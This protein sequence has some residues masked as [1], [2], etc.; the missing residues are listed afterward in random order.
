[1][2]KIN[3]GVVDWKKVDKKPKNVHVKTIN[4]NYAVELGKSKAFGFSLVGIGG[5]DIAQ[6]RTKLVLAIVWQMMRYHI[7]RF[8]TAMSGSSK[9]LTEADV[10][11][12]ANEKVAAQ[13]GLLP[14][15]KLSDATLASGVYILTLIK[16]VAPRA[17]D[18]QQVT[19]GM[20]AEEKKLNARLAVS[21]ARRAGCMI[22]ALWEDIV[23][24]K[25]KM[26]LVLFATLMQLDI[27][28]KSEAVVGEKRKELRRLS[29]LAE[30]PESPGKSPH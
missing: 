5:V 21:C 24:C 20:T 15:Q 12:W 2:D 28:N 14:V 27:K 29:V 3:P 9:A 26:L 13:S 18:L 7:I 6:K 4:C 23:E 30:G 11:K 16:A 17:V 1:M 25:P 10:L 22:F 8:L 19:P